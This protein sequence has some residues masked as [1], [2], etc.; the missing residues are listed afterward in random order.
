MRLKVRYF[1][2]T[3][4]ELLERSQARETYDA[5]QVAPL[6]R[7]LLMEGTPLLDVMN[8]KHPI[9]VIFRLR[10]SVD[11]AGL[12]APRP[13]WLAGAGLDPARPAPSPPLPILELRRDGFLAFEVGR[14]HGQQIRVCDIV[15][16]TSAALSGASTDAYDLRV[17][18]MRD[19]THAY[20][21]FVGVQFEQ[22]TLV[23]QIAD[24]LRG[25]GA[26]TAKAAQPLDQ[27]IAV[28]V[29]DRS[30]A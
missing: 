28:E 4:H 25:I 7:K 13:V 8:R 3:L 16:M 20:C 17:D 21:S 23:E 10:A 2:S 5:L 18:V 1:Q 26:V 15:E 19:L 27:R 30:T 12:E 24:L 29:D 9:A 6:V 14:V 22:L 11:Q